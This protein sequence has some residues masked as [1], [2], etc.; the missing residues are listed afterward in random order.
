MRPDPVAVEPSRDLAPAEFREVIGHFA[1]GVT[2]ITARH[3]GIAFG[4][5]ASAVSSLSLEPPMLLICMNQSS[6]TGRAIA[7]SGSYAVNV[8][9]EDQSDLAVRFATKSKDK[10][11]G[12]AVTSAGRGAPL[13]AEALATLECRVVEAVTGGTHWVFLAEV[14]RASARG[15]SPLAYF[16]GEFGRLDLAHDESALRELRRRVWHREVAVGEPLDL[17]ALA[18]QLNAPRGSIY[19]ALAKLSGEGLVDR[20]AAGSFVVRPVTLEAVLDSVRARFAI[21]LG[22]AALQREPPPEADLAE[23]RRALAATRPTRPDGR[24]V[25]IGDWFRARTAFVEALVA[26]T[27]SPALVE[28]ARRT[29]VPGMILGLWAGGAPPAPSDLER[30][31]RAYVD[32]VAA[33][34]TGDFCALRRTAGELLD[35]YEALHRATFTRHAGI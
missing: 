15:G 28:A 11:D 30:I 26:L 20:D 8:L 4:T 10:F 5:T 21:L 12:V 27:G 14:E 22:A 13:L 18:E 25:A 3:E 24:P 35:F 32:I 34:A 17:E 7:A 19:H 6:S 2:V 31:H 16:R 29:D 9:G 23:L 33:Y 1:S